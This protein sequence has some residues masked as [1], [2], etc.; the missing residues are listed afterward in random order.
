[1][2]S[3]ERKQGQKPVFSERIPESPRVKSDLRSTIIVKERREN[4]NKTSI[5]KEPKQNPV[6]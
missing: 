4:T 3:K 5:T 2:Q 1:M 6:K